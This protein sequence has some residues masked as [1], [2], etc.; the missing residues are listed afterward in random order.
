[1]NRSTRAGSPASTCSDEVGTSLVPTQAGAPELERGRLLQ[2]EVEQG[3]GHGGF[4]GVPGLLDE[5]FG[6]DARTSTV[7]VGQAV[8]SG[9]QCERHH[10]GTPARQGLFEPSLRIWYMRQFE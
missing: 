9:L 10:G 3:A 1:M 2:F 6:D 4:L 5:A 7:L 8:Q